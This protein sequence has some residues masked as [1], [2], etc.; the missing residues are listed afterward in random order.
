MLY[1]WQKDFVEEAIIAY[2]KAIGIDPDYYTAYNNLGVIYLDGIRNLKEAERLFKTAI[3]LK[4]DY[5]MAHFNLGRVYQEKGKNIEAA[6]YYQKA[7][8]INEIEAEMDSDE[9]RD[10]IFALFEV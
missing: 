7:L 5:V 8:E 3:S 1:D 4:N 10:R 6:Q 9:I 2:H